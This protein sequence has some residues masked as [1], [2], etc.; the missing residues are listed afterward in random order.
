M[1]LQC[2]GKSPVRKT[3]Y[4]LVLLIL[5]PETPLIINHLSLSRQRAGKHSE[6]KFLNYQIGLTHK[7]R[8]SYGILLDVPGDKFHSR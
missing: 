2:L 1:L 6:S 7:V 5:S 4:V 3:T 8:S